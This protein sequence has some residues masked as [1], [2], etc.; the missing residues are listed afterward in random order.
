MRQVIIE[1]GEAF[2]SVKN[3]KITQYVQEQYNRHI[4][5]A[6]GDVLLSLAD[7]SDREIAVLARSF[8]DK[9]SITSE[10]MLQGIMIV[11]AIDQSANRVIPVFE[12]KSSYFIN[13]MNTSSKV[14]VTDSA[15]LYE[16]DNYEHGGSG[17]RVDY[18]K[19][20]DNAKSGKTLMAVL[21]MDTV[22]DK[23]IPHSCTLMGDEL[24]VIRNDYIS[25]KFGGLNPF[26]E[27]EWAD[28][29]LACVC[30]RFL[31]EPSFVPLS[32]GL[33]A[34]V[35]E[36]L[37]AA[38]NHHNYFF[39]KQ[40]DSNL[41]VRD[42]FGR[43]IG[44]KMRLYSA[45]EVALARQNKRLVEPAKSPVAN[46]VGSIVKFPDEPHKAKA[47]KAQ[48]LMTEQP[49]ETDSSDL[50][51]TLVDDSFNGQPDEFMDNEDGLWHDDIDLL[52]D[53]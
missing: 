9:F 15:V 7:C 13:L 26:T 33:K 46:A 51:Q 52:M 43:V 45:E 1:L 48:K 6:T 27:H 8:I 35:I 34:E 17:R 42:G 5:S 20:P 4:P 19:Q 30:R 36:Q 39:K 16:G 41:L 2:R 29:Y 53:C 11:P 25:V 23:P 18:R 3:A 37:E 49:V 44:R 22:N 14:N 12:F 31:Q 47:A 10:Q 50:L 28:V 32:R 24:E 21:N 40:K 38:R